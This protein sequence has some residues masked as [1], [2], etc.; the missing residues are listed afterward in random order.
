VKALQA[1]HQEAE[2]YS[3]T[4]GDFNTYSLL[5]IPV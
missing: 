3:P 2:K 5:T 4:R 1:G